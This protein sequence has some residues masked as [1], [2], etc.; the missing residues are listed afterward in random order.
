[1]DVETQ[2]VVVPRPHLESRGHDHAPRSVPP[3]LEPRLNGLA[4]RFS[5]RFGPENPARVFVVA[6]L[7][8]YAL[9]VTAMV[10][11]GL[12]LIHVL[13]PI[14]GLAEAD[15][16]FSQW[17][18]DNRSPTQEDVSWVGSTLSGGHVIPAVIGICLVTFLI[19]R[20]WLLA[21]FVLFVVAV[22]SG[23][24]RVTS[25]I[26][27]RQRPDVPRLESLPVD[28]SYPSG[29]SAA[30]V[31]LYG[32]LLLLLASRFQSALVRIL[33]VVLGVAIPLFV[34]WSRMYRGMHHLSDI[35]A[36]LLMGLG[37]LVVLVFAARAA[38]A[39]ADRRDGLAT[40]RGGGTIWRPSP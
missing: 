20:R 9:L 27:E 28:A 24:Y 6:L 12:V 30:A 14:G 23:T 25:W 11:L 35:V 16:D 29:H 1:V 13:L 37:A 3:V 2:V 34:S 18:A 15:E 31:A 19:M 36:G 17:L 5:Q 33:A 4:D 39:A 38:R 21:A 10:F 40:E 7:A 32:G 26:V 22:E 8:G